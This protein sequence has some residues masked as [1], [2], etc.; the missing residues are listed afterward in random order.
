MGTQSA[1]SRRG[2]SRQPMLLLRVSLSRLRRLS[3]RETHSPSRGCQ[4]W[5]PISPTGQGCRPRFPTGKKRGLKSLD[6]LVECDT[7]T[8]PNRSFTSL[9]HQKER[10]L[11][12]PTNTLP[13]LRSCLT[14]GIS[15]KQ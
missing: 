1:G 8:M 4:S 2:L 7:I 5:R 9:L 13:I 3:A 12:L 15:I 10:A 11:P 14:E 6:R